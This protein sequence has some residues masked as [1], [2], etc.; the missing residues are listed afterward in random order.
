MLEY[1]GSSNSIY[2]RQLSSSEI[3]LLAFSPSESRPLSS[4]QI[5]CTLQTVPFRAREPYQHSHCETP[6]Y[7]AISYA[8]HEVP[9]QVE[10][11]CNGQPTQISTNLANGLCQMWMDEPTILVW[12]DALSINQTDDE[13]KSSQVGQMGAIFA[14]AS[15]VHVWLGPGTGTFESSVP[16]Y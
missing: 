10:I 13:E 6:A 5:R 9:C 1:E 2:N 7:V 14:Q 15:V 4:Q 16:D 12:A 8:W 11:I 3:R